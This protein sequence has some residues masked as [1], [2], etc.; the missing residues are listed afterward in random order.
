MTDV[1]F[2]DLGQ[3]GDGTDAAIG[4]TVACVDLKPEAMRVTGHVGQLGQFRVT[5]QQ[6]TFG[7]S[8]TIGTRV[9]LNHLCTNPV[10]RINLAR[11]GG[12]KN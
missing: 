6:I 10:R 2:L 9:Q 4:Q 3:C 1:K 7:K 12:N 5:G 11:I 8:V